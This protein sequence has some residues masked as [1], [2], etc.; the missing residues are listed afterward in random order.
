MPTTLPTQLLRLIAS[1]A[2]IVLLAAHL[3]AATPQKPA[4]APPNSQAQLE[5][6]VKDLETRLA[7]AEQ[8]ADKAAMEKDYSLRTRN[9]YEA[10]YKEVFSTQTHIL[11]T[12]G[13]TATLLSITL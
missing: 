7:A 6:R 12:I 5:A 9:H 2:V 10:Y 13:I 1:V 8:K 3:A 11:W 4:A